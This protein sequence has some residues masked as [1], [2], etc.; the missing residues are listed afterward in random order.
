MTTYTI[1]K[2]DV[3]AWSANSDLTDRMDT[4]CR[5]FEA[6]AMRKLRIRRMEASFNGTT[7]SNVVALPADW[8]QFKRIWL[9]GY[10]ECELKPQTL[11]VVSGR[12]Q[13]LPTYYA[14]DGANVRFDGEGD[15]AGVYYQ[16][17]PS[18]TSN[19]SN[20]L[21]TAAYDAYLFGMLAEVADYL[22]D[23]AEL[24]KWQAKSES[25]LSDLIDADRRVY[26]P[27]VSVKR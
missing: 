12:T 23:D 8:L 9:T 1:L 14:T 11:T 19:A 26:G 17:I 7:A 25:I 18:L 13:G 6:R 22:K 24:A 5:L 16:T 27:L 4:L 21:L 20:W 15:V 2:A 10:P 3:A